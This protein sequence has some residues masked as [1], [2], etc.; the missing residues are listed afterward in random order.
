[1]HLSH[2]SREALNHPDPHQLSTF[3]PRGTWA[4]ITG[5]SDGIGKEFALSLAAKGYN[6][7]LVS[8]TQSKLD[9]LSADITSKYGPK[10]PTTTT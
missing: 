4:L 1:M 7:I 10:M 5:A 8:R 3:G 2:S 6:L 9:S